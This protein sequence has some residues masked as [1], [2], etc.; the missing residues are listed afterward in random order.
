[1]MRSLLVLFFAFCS[2]AYSGYT[3]TAV[4]M[5]TNE[6]DLYLSHVTG[7]LNNGNFIRITVD[8]DGD[9]ATAWEQAQV[10]VCF[11]NSNETPADDHGN[12]VALDGDYQFT[13]S[14]DGETVQINL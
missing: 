11:T 12:F 6:D 4:A 7:Y 10:G 5:D 14:G 13:A 9:D 8:I 3:I 1:M 2:V